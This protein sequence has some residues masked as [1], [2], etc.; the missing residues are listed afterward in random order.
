MPTTKISCFYTQGTGFHDRV[1]T[2]GAQSGQQSKL[3]DRLVEAVLKIPPTIEVRF[4]SLFGFGAHGL[5]KSISRSGLQVLSPVSLRRGCL[6]EITIA[7]CRA[8]LGEVLYCLKRGKVYQLGIVFCAR[9][10]PEI[11]VGCLASIMALEEPFSVSRGHVLDIG[12]SHLSILCKTM[13]GAGAWARVEADGWT[14]FG[15][16][17]AVVP[18]SMV[19]CCVDIHLEAAFPSALAASTETAPEC[20]DERRFPPYPALWAKAAGASAQSLSRVIEDIAIT[21][22][23]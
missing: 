19:A 10:K 13:L 16:V 15:V 2:K 21:P 8:I 23:V 17:D 9:Q 1:D 6:L 20:P 11:P 3:P 4:S 18:T 22:T 5:L 7:H 12:S 14:L